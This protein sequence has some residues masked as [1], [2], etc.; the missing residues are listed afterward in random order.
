MNTAAGALLAALSMVAAPAGAG[1]P[2]L[3]S[4]PE[5]PYV[6][7]SQGSADSNACELSGSGGHVVFESRAVQLVEGDR[8]G[9]E[10]VFLRDRAGGST[11]RI[12]RYADGSENPNG[13][14]APSVSNGGRYVAFVSQD[15]LLDGAPGTTPQIYRYDRDSGALRLVS[16]TPAGAPGNGASSLPH[17]AGNGRYIAFDS[18][19]TDLVPGDGNGVRDIFLWDAQTDAVV[20]VSVDAA[21]A[22]ADGAS[23]QAKVSNDGSRVAF[24]SAATNLVAGDTL[25]LRDVFVKLLDTGVVRRV[26]VSSGGAQ[27]S[28]NSDIESIA[29]N[30]RSVAFVSAATNLVSGDTNGVTDL[31]VHTLPSGVTR[32]ANVSASGQQGTASAANGSLSDDG[33]WII[34]VSRDDNLVGPLPGY[35]QVFRKNLDTEAI[36]LLTYGQDG[37]AIRAALSGDGST[38]CFSSFAT[39]LIAGDVNEAL[40]VFVVAAAVPFIAELASLATPPAPLTAG[41]QR[42][43]G[44]DLSADGRYVVFSALGVID[45]ETFIEAGMRPPEQVYRLDRDSG[46]IVRAS[47]DPAGQSGDAGSDHARISADGRYVAYQSRAANLA[48]GDGNGAADIFRFDA[49]TGASVLVSLS[50]SGS[51]GEGERPSI[52]A[53]GS[54]VAFSSAGDDLVAGDGNGHEDVFVW[55]D[56][57]GLRLISRNTLGQPGNGDSERAEISGNGRYVVFHSRASDLVADDGNGSGDVFVH[58]LLLNSTARVNLSADGVE[59]DAGAD[60]PHISHSGRYVVFVSYAGNLV[61]DDD[62]DDY[63][64]FL[65]DRLDGSI[66]RVSAELATMLALQYPYAPRVSADGSDVFFLA[67]KIA[68]GVA[69]LMRY[70]VGSGE[71][72]QLLRGDPGRETVSNRPQSIA[73]AG[74]GTQLAVSWP[75]RLSPADINDA[76]YS[77]VYVLPVPI[78]DDLI[79]GNGFEVP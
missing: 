64:V 45:T 49:T 74:D 24:E 50:T 46:A 66:V 25:G 75:D 69:A 72:S 4:A 76:G 10:D 29:G 5:D 27:A 42:S 17:I 15:R 58:D 21:G 70:H 59:A 71:L 44:P 56:V 12:N 68:D 23:Q 18:V 63:D 77:D 39:D 41:T 73:I 34:F 28:G 62:N 65:V 40:D 51:A 33:G 36:E 37:A 43:A 52:A 22:E 47:S 6:L 35:G 57:H 32:R 1:T 20:R 79:F 9:Q 67:E 19:A 38:A 61:P 48:P 3:V 2:I 54:V 60:E 78:A 7:G 8:N 55:S 14:D 13:A 11:E 30:G 26:S 31:F 53:D 16:R